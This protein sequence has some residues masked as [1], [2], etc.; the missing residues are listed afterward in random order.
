MKYRPIQLSDFSFKF[1]GYGHYKVTYYS[2]NTSKSWSKVTDN[3]CLIDDT[4]NEEYPKQKDLITLK[5]LCK[6]S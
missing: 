1:K 4:K 5:R 2:P 3:M 6:N